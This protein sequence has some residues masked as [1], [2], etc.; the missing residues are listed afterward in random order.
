MRCLKCLILVVGLLLMVDLT[1]AEE[2]S[3]GEVSG[4]ISIQ[5][6]VT[7][8]QKEASSLTPKESTTFS[9]TLFIFDEEKSEVTY[10]IKKTLE[11]RSTLSSTFTK[12]IR[13]GKTVYKLT[14]SGKGNYDKYEDITWTVEAE[15]E[16]KDG[17]LLPNYSIHTLFDNTGKTIIKYEKKYDYDKEKIFYT[18]TDANG[19]VLKNNTFPMKGKTVDDFTM[20]S[21]LRKFIPHLNEE[22]YKTYYLLTSEPKL[23]K[24]DIKVI[25]EETL[26]LPAGKIETIKIRIIPDLGLLTGV[27]KAMVPPTYL[28]FT[29]KEPYMWVK[30][31]GL[32]CGLGSTHIVN[33]ITQSQPPLPTE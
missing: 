10:L 22:G 2:I 24:I 16:E 30:Y 21:F 3:E 4:E 25:G 1:S 15:M 17:F 12:L 11:P 29:K 14:Q 9:P 20:V 19:K 8:P 7:T 26:E 32:E 23:Y 13:E 31:E 28:W 5:E 6:E 27:A 33:Y 18:A